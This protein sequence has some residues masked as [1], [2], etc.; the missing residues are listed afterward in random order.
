MATP[1][2]QS[3]EVSALRG[4]GTK[5]SRIVSQSPELYGHQGAY[6]DQ[7]SSSSILIWLV[8]TPT[9]ISKREHNAISDQP[10]EGDKLKE[11]SRLHQEDLRDEIRNDSPDHTHPA[12]DWDCLLFWLIPVNK[13][14]LRIVHDEANSRFRDAVP[15]IS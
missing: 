4:A 9:K 7:I 13:A 1:K 15:V 12:V 2:K 6:L 14:A 5:R 3:P 10:E 11:S 8:A